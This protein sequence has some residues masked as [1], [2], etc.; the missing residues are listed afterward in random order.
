MVLRMILRRVLLF[1]QSFFSL[2]I[3]TACLCKMEEEGGGWSQIKRVTIERVGLFQYIPRK[4]YTHLV[5]MSLSQAAT[6]TYCQNLANFSQSVSPED[7]N[8]FNSPY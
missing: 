3:G 7:T 5:G 2:L 4:G 1:S 6:E 8:T